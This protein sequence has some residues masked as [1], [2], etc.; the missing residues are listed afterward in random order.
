MIAGL[1]ILG[2][3]DDQHEAAERATE[4]TF[5]LGFVANAAGAL[6]TTK[7]GAQTAIPDRAAI[8]TALKNTANVPI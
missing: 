2:L 4:L 8:L 3:L 1:I 7:P 6:A 5:G